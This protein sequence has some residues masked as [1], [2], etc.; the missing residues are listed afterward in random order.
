MEII[1]KVKKAAKRTLK[2]LFEPLRRYNQAQADK[3]RKVFWDYVETIPPQK[4]DEWY[5]FYS[6]GTKRK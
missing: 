1:K 5:K 3:D 6:E 2:G 4:R